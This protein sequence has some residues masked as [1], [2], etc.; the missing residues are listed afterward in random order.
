MTDYPLP[1]RASRLRAMGLRV[2]GSGGQ[3]VV[4]PTEE[5]TDKL[6]MAIIASREDL[7]A[8]VDR[9]FGRTRPDRWEEV[10]AALKARLM[11]AQGP[12]DMLFAYTG[13]EF[14]QVEAGF[15]P[16]EDYA[17]PVVSDWVGYRVNLW[18]CMRATRLPRERGRVSLLEMIGSAPPELVLTAPKRTRG[19][20]AKS[21]LDRLHCIAV[22]QLP[23]NAGRDG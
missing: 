21:E 6:R 9:G 13:L 22:V 4:G 19:R 1:I 8:E 12:M 15:A 14:R 10:A 16:E 11:R 2:Y 17:G 7:L 5:L 18:R 20:F 23:T 3:L